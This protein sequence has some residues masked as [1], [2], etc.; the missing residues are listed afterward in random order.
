MTEKLYYKDPYIEEFESKVIS[1]EAYEDK[2]KVVLEKTAFFPEEGGQYSDRGFLNEIRV[3]DAFEDNGIIYHVTESAIKPGETVVGRIDFDERYE[4]MQCHSAEHIL[5]GLIHTHYGLDNVGFHL[6]AEEVTMDISAPLTYEQLMK[7]ENMANEVVYKNLPIDCSFP[8]KSELSKL[9][10]RSK[11]SVEE[12]LRI[13]TIGEYDRCACC[14]PHVKSTGEIGLI[15]ILDFSCLRGGIRIR[16]SAGRRAMRIFN[17][18]QQNLAEISRLT[19]TPRLETAQAVKRVMLAAEETKNELKNTRLTLYKKEASDIRN[20]EGNAVLVFSDATV[21]ELR[22]IANIA[23]SKI[24]GILVLLSGEEKN[25]KY[26]IASNCIDL[27]F[28]AKNINAALCG[29]GGGSANMIQGVFLAEISKIREYFDN[30]I[31]QPRN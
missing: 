18:M 2:F 13:V 11:I 23:V 7:I 17:A 31:L 16:I 1:C 6:G 30:T 22:T 4:K 19:S 24:G 5:S 27:R 10:Y 29:K 3:C 14:A 8:D 26:V 25:Y 15:K 20:C 9:E 21:D 12:N 28:E